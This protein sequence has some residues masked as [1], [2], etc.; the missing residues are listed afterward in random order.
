M[1]IKQL[2]VFV[3]LQFLLNFFVVFGAQQ[4]DQ[5]S[6]RSSTSRLSKSPLRGVKKVK[7]MQCKVT[8]LDGADFTVNVEVSRRTHCSVMVIVVLICSISRVYRIKGD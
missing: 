1:I 4:D 3:L 5:E 2:N 8:L 6:R 7:T